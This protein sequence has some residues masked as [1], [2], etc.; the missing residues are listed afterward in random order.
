MKI[1]VTEVNDFVIKIEN[2][3]ARKR[4]SRLI[5]FLI[6][7]RFIPVK[8]DRDNSE[9]TFKLSFSFDY[10]FYHDLLGR[11]ISYICN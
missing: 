8:L 3:S 4:I 11:T 5:K 10:F 1:E 9:A 2:S 7:I 6:K